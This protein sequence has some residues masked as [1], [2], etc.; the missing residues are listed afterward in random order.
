MRVDEIYNRLNEIKIFNDGYSVFDTENLNSYFGRDNKN[1]TVFMM[2]SSS[3]NKLPICQETKTLKLLTNKKV[4]IRDSRHNIYY[5]TVHILLCKSQEEY[6]VKA[7]VRLTN[8]FAIDGP[9]SQYDIFR[10]FA[11]ISSL[12]DKDRDI[13]EKEIQGLFGELYTIIFLKNFNCDIARYWQSKPKMKF[14]FS[15]NEKKRIEVKSTLKTERVH[16]FKHEQLLDELYDIKVVSIKLRKSD[17]GISLNNLV[18]KIH[19]LYANNYNLLLYIEKII[20]KLNQEYVDS[21]QYD[22]SYLETNIA[23]FDA[24]EIPHFNVKTPE[25]VYNAE[26]DCNLDNICSL[27]LP[28]M[29]KWLND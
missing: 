29:V 26:Y 21:F 19:E 25:G 1:N 23:I 10:L 12:F 24:K 5:K 27:S 8:A 16:H 7:F 20:G 22:K 6:T 4:K 14:D 2:D 13:S 9:V 17:G 28:E 15:I 3:P 18:D 11:S